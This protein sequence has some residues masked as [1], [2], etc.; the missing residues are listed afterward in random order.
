MSKVRVYAYAELRQYIGG[1]AAIEVE[2]ADDRTVASLLTQLG[3]PAER[4]KIVFVNSRAAELNRILADGE[5][6][7]L[8]SAIGGG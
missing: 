4:T 5:R 3:I 1:S 8:F 6:V 7:D 2:L